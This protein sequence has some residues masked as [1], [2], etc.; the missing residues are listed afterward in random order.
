MPLRK[1]Q[2]DAV[3]E[4]F[5]FWEKS[6]KPC[7]LQLATGA[8]KSHIIAEIV[9]KVNQPTLILQPTKEILE[10]NKE[11]LEMIGI[12]PQVCSSSAGDWKIGDITLATIGT[13]RN[14]VQYCSRFK[15][16]IVDE[17]DVVPNDRADSMYMEFFNDPYLSDA[18]IIGLTACVDGETEVLTPMGFVKFEELKGESGIFAQWT[19]PTEGSL[20]KITFE[21]ASIFRGWADH[22]NSSMWEKEGT[23][24]LFTDNHTIPIEFHKYNGEVYHKDEKSGKVKWNYHKRFYMA[25][26]GAGNSRS[27][28]DEEKLGIFLQADGTYVKK[29]EKGNRKGLCYHAFAIKKDKK[30][31][32]VEPI[33]ER[34]EMP[35]RWQSDG[36][37]TGEVYLPFNA[38]KMSN[39][40]RL[41]EFSY[42]KAVE[43]VKWMA[44]FDGHAYDDG[45]FEYY[46][47][48]KD[49]ANFVQAVACLGG[50]MTRAV[51]ITKGG[52]HQDY[53]KLYIRPRATRCTDALKGEKRVEWNKP[54]YCLHTKTGYF[55][56]RKN[57]RVFITGNT[58]W[59]NQTF[60]R[61]YEDPRVYCRPVTRIHTNGGKDTKYG[62][63]FWNKIIY[64]CSISDLQ[65]MDFLSKTQYYFV[66][67]DWSFIEDVPG[68]VEYEMEQM[69][70]WVD[71]DENTS[72]F[73]KA[74]K[75]CI[76]NNLKTIV[77][78]PNVDMN[79]QLNNVIM[80]LGGA[81][82]T[83]DSVYDN[84]KTRE[85]KMSA[86]RSGEVQFLVN[87]GMVGRG[88]DVPSVDCVI[89]CRPTKSLSFWVQGVGR[90]LRKDP[91]NPDKTAYIIDLTENMKRFG[92]AEDVTIEKIDAIS[93]NGISYKQDAIMMKK[94]GRKVVWDR[95]S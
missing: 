93:R 11:K 30:V 90:C 66:P 36:Y 68:R 17:G 19:P 13:I 47:C 22:M 26:G 86:L 94:G 8:G 42:E 84:C 15:V 52:S 40:L 31:Q 95:V 39:F 64:R 67:T 83:L 82:I 28:T 80:S 2:Q 49:N 51:M 3:D 1:Y 10:Q 77:F 23:E 61:A 62:E 65:E 27:L 9:K 81:S 79:F 70:Q 75:W 55:V 43:F 33:L 88:V 76:D 54:V 87:V 37:F 91:N 59:R 7:I 78:S 46:S 29:R 48:D 60:Q 21:E 41:E 74:I 20:G 16:I 44:L 5:K 72:T 32:A 50:F 6:S 85:A 25:G 57:G 63:W 35:H 89:W 69:T 14:W 18:K 73:T 12:C 45:S 58:P 24:F 34:L 71:V 92:K 4:L 56:A 38:K 53:W